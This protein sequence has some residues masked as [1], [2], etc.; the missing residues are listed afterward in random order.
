MTAANAEPPRRPAPSRSHRVHRFLGRLHRMLDDLETGTSWP[1]TIEDL[2]EC[3]VEAYAAQR[4]L[5]EL[6]LGL[7]A[8]A[9]SSGLAAHDGRVN[10]V[11]WLRARVLLAPNEAKR[12]VRLARA[13]AEHPVTREALAAGRIPVASA[14]VI[15]DAVDSLPAD[16]D[17]AVRE[18][19]ETFLAG[20]AHAHDTHALRRIADHLDEV[21]DPDGADA[22]LAEQLA[23]AEARAARTAFLTLRHDEATQTTDGSF[24]VPLVHGVE[25]QRMIEALLNPGRRDPLPSDDPTTGVRLS[26]GERRGR[27]L[28]E[29]IERIPKNELPA[30]G[31][32]DPVVVVTMD[33]DTLVGGLE[34]ARLDTGHVI[35]PGQARR[36]AARHGVIPA[37]LG[38]DSEVLDLG[39]RVR[40]FTKKQ[41]LG[42]VVQQGG[43]CAVEGCGRPATWGDAHHLSPWHR[44]GRTDLREGVLVC[45]RHHVLADHPDYQVTRLRP[46][47]I[48]LTRRQ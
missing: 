43:V 21:I 6:T 40:F 41:R 25:L 19:A 18:R 34:A 36:L 27:A 8:Q 42:M 5:A 28:A 48:R 13:L 24:R 20:E 46:G 31:G 29:L 22:R 33:L 45:R 15:L 32:C 47:R 44:G 37:V 35:G 39:R 14:A 9:E 12:Q 7:V 30:T 17:P 1:L 38:S 4:R 23:R 10:T 16:L 2:A 11:A 26:P 3:I